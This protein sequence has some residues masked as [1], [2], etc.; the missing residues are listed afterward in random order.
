MDAITFDIVGIN[1]VMDTLHKFNKQTQQG[2]KDEVAASALK[3]QS[4][5]KRNAPVNL[6]TL[7]QSI[8]LESEVK[9]DAQYTFK[10]GSSA[11]YAPYI[12]FGTGGKVSI[13]KGFESYA[14]QFKVKSKGRFKEMLLA[15]TEWVQKKGIASGKESKSVAYMIAISILRKGLRPQPFLIPAFELEKIKLKAT[16][17]KIIKDA[18][19]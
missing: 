7:R 2:I 16:I 8:Y 17:E 18:K 15:L 1:K 11:S 14:A 10:I 4:D 13:P 5:A 9:N 12:E 6:G 3:I 19:P